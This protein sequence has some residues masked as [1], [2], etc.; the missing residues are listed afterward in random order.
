MRGKRA[1]Q[2]RRTAEQLGKDMSE[3]A[4]ADWSNPGY[5]QAS[6]GGFIKVRPGMPKQMQP[7]QRLI[8]Q[9]LKKQNLRAMLDDLAKHA[10]SREA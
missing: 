3:K 9:K 7:C 4:Y 10:A 5:R 8:Y 6:D 2:L 1:K